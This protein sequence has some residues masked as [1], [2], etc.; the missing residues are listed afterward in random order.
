MYRP[1]C[2]GRSTKAS[3]AHPRHSQGVQRCT[4]VSAA[5][6]APA[7]VW[8]DCQD[9]PGQWRLRDHQLW[10]ALADAWVPP[11]VICYTLP[12][13]SDFNRGAG[14]KLYCQVR[15]NFHFRCLHACSWAALSP[16]CKALDAASSFAI[17]ILPRTVGCERPQVVAVI[18]SLHMQHGS[19]IDGP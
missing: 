17:G 8:E 7:W 10:S 3:L 4:G 1:H 14:H 18:A 16:Y 2:Q 12:F 6:F 13:H 15:S 11:R 5:L 19:L 9:R